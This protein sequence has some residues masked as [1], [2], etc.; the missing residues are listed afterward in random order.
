[1][2]ED[3]T[4]PRTYECDYFMTSHCHNNDLEFV[5]FVCIALCKDNVYML[6]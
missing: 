6:K 2:I 4:P 1:M 3:S 5:I